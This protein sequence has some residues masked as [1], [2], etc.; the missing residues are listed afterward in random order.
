[1][2]PARATVPYGSL[3]ATIELFRADG[4]TLDSDSDTVTA[5]VANQ[6]LGL[7]NIGTGLVDLSATGNGL[8][9]VHAGGVSGTDPV[10]NFFLDVQDAYGNW[11]PSFEPEDGL[12]G[13][14]GI[15]E[16]G[17][18]AAALSAAVIAALTG[19]LAWTV[20]SG[21]SFSGVSLDVYGR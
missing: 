8:L 12:F 17:T 18:Y 16:A 10:L 5:E 19:R 6:L 9:I 13:S 21:A 4:L 1:M 3:T 11:A 15:T 20:S 2:P 7:E 14:P